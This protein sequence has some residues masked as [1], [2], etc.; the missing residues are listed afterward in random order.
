MS[1]KY[2]TKAEV[3][4]WI[5]VQRPRMTVDDIPDIFMNKGHVKVD[6]V[7]LR[8]RVFTFP[9]KND[10]HD[11]LK[12][13]AACFILAFLARARVITQTSGEIATDKFRDV[14]YQ[15]QRTQPMF[16]FA[17]GSSE[18][19]QMLLPHETLRMLAFEFLRAYRRYRFYVDTGQKQ[20]KG[21]VV[22]DRTSRGAGWNIRTSVIEAADGQYGDTL[23]EDGNPFEYK[24]D[25]YWW[26]ED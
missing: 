7:L 26:E 9:T 5:N 10:K 2:V 18:P 16:F 12:H 19:F 17:S 22:L 15:F 23:T 20:P 25:P 6:A 4:Q 24:T 11:F 13:A 8:M 3:L 21:V 1:E 14:T